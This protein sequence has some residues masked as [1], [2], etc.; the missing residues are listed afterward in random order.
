MHGL[1]AARLGA[2]EKALRYFHHTAGID[3]ALHLI[4]MECGESMAA[5]V[6]EAMMVYLRRSSRD[7]Q[8][9]PFLGHRRHVH[10][11]VHKVQDAIAAEPA[12]EWDMAALAGVGHV[13]ERHLLRLFMDHAGVSPMQCLQTI[14]LERA[15]Q[16]LE[17]GASVTLAAEASGFRSSLNLRRA[18][19]KQWG[20]SPRDARRVKSPT[21]PRLPA[22]DR[23]R[24]C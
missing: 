1:A 18:W 19:N 9:S 6:A 17:H 3:L 20:G 2:T 15:R 12:R 10:P 21:K 16:S 14:R 8:L 23:L 5:G 13:T 7:P 11:V 4:G 24:V 22:D